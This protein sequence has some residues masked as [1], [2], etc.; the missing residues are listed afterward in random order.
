MEI[1]SIYSQV[2]EGA[3]SL[4]AQVDGTSRNIEDEAMASDMVDKISQHFPENFPYDRVVVQY[5]E[6]QH[7]DRPRMLILKDGSPSIFY[8]NDLE[9]ER[10]AFYSFLSDFK[11]SIEEEL[12]K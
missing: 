8:L 11:A 9:S 5:A 1:Q 2:Y 4:S 6:S 3:P 10:P 12:K 7:M